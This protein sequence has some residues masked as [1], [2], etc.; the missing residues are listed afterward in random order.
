MFAFLTTRLSRLLLMVPFDGNRQK[1][2][3][4]KSTPGQASLLMYFLIQS[5]EWVQT[6]ASMCCTLHIY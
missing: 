1:P 4:T 6:G 5:K 2:H 3:P